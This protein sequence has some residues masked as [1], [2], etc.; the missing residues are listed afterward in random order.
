MAQPNYL[1]DPQEILNAYGDMVFRAAYSLTKNRQDAEDAAQEVFITLV[2]KQPKF[3]S[4]AHQKA[5]LLRAVANRCK[6][7]FRTVW[8]SRTEGIAEDFPSAD[9]TK[10]EQGVTDAINA[11]PP[12]YKHVIY[13]YYIEGYSTKEIAKLLDITQNA[14]LSRMARARALLKEII[15]EHDIIKTIGKDIGGKNF[16]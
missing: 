4:E 11:L 15:G 2:E 8:H 1:T 7:L 12:K 3:E 13:L 14:V 6:S 9:F 10:D 16:E 5:W